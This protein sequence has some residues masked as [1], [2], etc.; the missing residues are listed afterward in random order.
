MPAAPR[1]RA[2][3]E[4]RSKTLARATTGGSELQDPAERTRPQV[5]DVPADHGAAAAHHLGDERTAGDPVRKDPLLPHP[6]QL[7]EQ[8]AQRVDVVLGHES[9]AR[10]DMRKVLNH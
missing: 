2:R 3:T 9:K 1:S 10:H 8:P 7:R 5:A 6:A 4:R